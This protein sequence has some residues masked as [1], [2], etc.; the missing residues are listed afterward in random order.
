MN[1]PKVKNVY[2]KPRGNK[3]GGVTGVFLFGGQV[4]KHIGLFFLYRRISYFINNDK[5]VERIDFI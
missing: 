4:K 1:H 3:R 5:E 2:S